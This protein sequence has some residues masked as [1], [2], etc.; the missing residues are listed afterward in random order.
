MGGP[1]HSTDRC[2]ALR[3]K[4][5]DLRNQKLLNFEVEQETKP[6]VTQNPLPPHANANNASSSTNAVSRGNRAFDPSQ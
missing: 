6:N 2:Y 3:H 5:Q 1:G 4:V